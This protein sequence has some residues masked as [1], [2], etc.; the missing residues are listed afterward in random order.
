M[1][2]RLTAFSLLLVA[3]S[4]IAQEG[5][6]AKSLFFGE[7]DSVLVAP[8][9]PKALAASNQAKTGS[10]TKKAVAST[11][12]PK[13]KPAGSTQIGA[14]YFIRLK[15][16][17]GTTRDVLANRKFK[18]GERFQL[19]VKVNHPTYVYI[20]NEGPDGKLTQIYP[21]QG[22]D[23]YINAMGTVFLP[24][25]GSFE[26]DGVPG[27]EQLLVYLSSTPIPGKVTDQIRSAS[28]DIVSVARD[29]SDSGICAEVGS[30]LN[31]KIQVASAETGYA[32]KGIAFKAEPAAACVSGKAQAEGYA[33]K[34]ISFSE[35]PEPTGGGQVAS[36]VVK[37]TAK[38]DRN[39][40]LKLK[41]A[42]E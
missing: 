11:S 13:K 26:F 8:T 21:P 23:N 41:L 5:Y 17:D 29:S 30:A 27:T 36:Y 35:D 2:Y 6:S 33:S 28:P 9:G 42:H 7:D 16:S 12:I 31:E 1:R 22:H 19:G 39:L 20:A 10:E 15:N 40:Y 25:R 18:S 38:S 32:S 24:S 34:G 3:S 4:T 14:S 37:T